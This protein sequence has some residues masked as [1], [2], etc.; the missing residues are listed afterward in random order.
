MD[1]YKT[2]HPDLDYCKSAEEACTDADLCLLLTEWN[3]Y[4]QMDLGKLSEVMAGNAFLDCRNVYDRARLE[5]FG[6]RYDC[7]G[8]ASERSE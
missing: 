2:V 8:R 6:F 7:F 4:R 5:E 3:Q 1:N